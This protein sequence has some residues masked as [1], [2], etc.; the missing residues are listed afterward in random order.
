MERRK[1]KKKKRN[2]IET[3]R[4]GDGDVR[5]MYIRYALTDWINVML[6]PRSII[7]PKKALA[8]RALPSAIFF[9]LLSY[10]RIFC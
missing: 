1:K 3:R 10:P 9:F 8:M 6:S 7:R 4:V 2:K 5:K